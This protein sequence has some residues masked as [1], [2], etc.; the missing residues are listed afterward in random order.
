MV[1][2]FDLKFLLKILKKRMWFI[3]LV[4]I[5]ASGS[6]FYFSKYYMK[7]TYEASSKLIVNKIQENPGLPALDFNTVNLNIKL[8]EVYK[9]IIKSPA[10]MDIVAR[11]NPELGYTSE[12]LVKQVKVSGIAQTPIMIM[13]VEDGSHE[14]AVKIINAVA[15]VFQKQIPTIMKVDN[16]VI[17]NE[18]KLMDQP[19]PVSPVPYLNTVLAMTVSLIAMLSL[20]FILEYLN[21]T[22]QS[23][24]DIW[25]QLGIP[26]LTAIAK[27]KR[28]DLKQNRSNYSNK[29]VGEANHV[30]V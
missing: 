3:F 8:I 5:V 20:V 9:E 11:Q 7:P 18:A 2:E 1:M 25:S 22:V 4:V 16:V 24:E 12:Q 29:K 21:D 14:R 6:T 30:S 28:R 27:V 23:E 19:A 15:N 13:S 26:T 10:I 17:L